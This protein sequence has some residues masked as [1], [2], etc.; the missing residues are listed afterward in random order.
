MLVRSSRMRGRKGLACD[1]F[2]IF[3]TYAGFFHDVTYVQTAVLGTSEK[4][5]M[6]IMFLAT[7]ECG[8]F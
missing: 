2:D 7:F 3:A 1:V 8:I 4:A 5:A 6:T